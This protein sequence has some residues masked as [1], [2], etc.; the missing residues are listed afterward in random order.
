MASQCLHSDNLVFFFQIEVLSSGDSG[1]SQ[2]ADKDK[3]SSAASLE[4]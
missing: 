2:P 3:S 4:F 1:S